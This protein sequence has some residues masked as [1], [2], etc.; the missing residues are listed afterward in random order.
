MIK[1]LKVNLELMEMMHYYWKATSE[2][3]K[4]GEKYIYAII[5]HPHM[6][7]LYTPSFKEENARQVLSAI[8]NREIYKS[9]SKEAARFWNNNM[10]MMEDLGVTDAMFKPIKQLNLS[11][12]TN[13]PDYST[14]FERVELIFVPG[15]L[16]TTYVKG[17]QIYINFFKLMTDFVDG[18]IAIESQP[19]ETYVAKLLSAL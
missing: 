3:E 19:L 13:N 4:V 12:F 11:A 5:E 9:D 17:H 6:K 8:S 1:T 10:W 18:S 14:S 7:P 2:K 16:E 15:H